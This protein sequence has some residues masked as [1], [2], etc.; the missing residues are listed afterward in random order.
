MVDIFERLER[1]QMK[2]R[3]RY[4]DKI[5]GKPSKLSRMIAAAIVGVDMVF[6]S[7]VV[8]NIL[9]ILISATPLATGKLAPLC[10]LV[11]YSHYLV[12]IKIIITSCIC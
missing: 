8:I 7:R 1:K 2:R 10:E 5:A 11:N 6:V 12:F 9:V 4:Q 3:K